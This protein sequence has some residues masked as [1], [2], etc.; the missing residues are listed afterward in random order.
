[1]IAMILLSGFLRRLRALI[2]AQTR[3][4]SVGFNANKGQTTEK[5]EIGLTTANGFIMGNG[6]AKS[7]MLP[8]V[9]RG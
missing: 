6:S 5:T 1:M 2:V 3:H 8:V 4:A 7:I 9:C